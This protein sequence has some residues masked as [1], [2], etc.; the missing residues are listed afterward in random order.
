MMLTM[1]SMFGETGIRTRI[2]CSGHKT[3]VVGSCVL[4]RRGGTKG[5]C[6][7]STP[8]LYP[9]RRLRKRVLRICP[10]RLR[11][12][13]IVFLTLDFSVYLNVRFRW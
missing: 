11:R 4:E 3:F 7:E 9:R 13:E 10:F 5:Y 6:D 12:K 1:I 8:H 2:L